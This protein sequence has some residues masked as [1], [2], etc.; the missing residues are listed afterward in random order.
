MHYFSKQ[1]GP[2][3]RYAF[4]G[5]PCTCTTESNLLPPMSLIRQEE[6]VHYDFLKLFFGIG[7]VNFDIKNPF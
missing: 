2:Y 6:G 4:H 7:E 1:L 5:N 3:I